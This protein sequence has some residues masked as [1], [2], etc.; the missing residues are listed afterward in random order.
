M[1]LPSPHDSEEIRTLRSRYFR[2]VDTRRW[3]RLPELFTPDARFEGFAFETPTPAAFAENLAVFLDGVSTVHQGF[4]PELRLCGEGRVR[5]I[6]TMHDSLRWKPGSRDY[7]GLTGPDLCGIEG[8]GHYEDEYLKTAAG[9]LI[10]YQRLSRL[11]V[12][13]VVVLP[14]DAER[15]D[16]P[17]LRPDWL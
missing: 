11:R 1:N 8:Y 7:R 12:D 2:Y 10:D 4:A 17:V 9:W 13:P 14:R 3:D 15:V 16:S 5:G 6:W